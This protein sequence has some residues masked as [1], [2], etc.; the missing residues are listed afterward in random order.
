MRRT[1]LVYHFADEDSLVLVGNNGG[2]DY[3][4][5]WYHNLT[6]DPAVWI[7]NRD[8]FYQANAVSI[9]DDEHPQIWS[10]LVEKLP[11]LAESQEKVDRTIPLVRVT[12]IST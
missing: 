7:R 5:D 3:H 9:D 8:N 2:R 4:P 12:R 10:R 1:P 6:A 11:H